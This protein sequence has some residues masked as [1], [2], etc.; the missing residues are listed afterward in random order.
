VESESEVRAA[1]AELAKAGISAS[2]PKLFAQYAPDY[3]A[4]FFS[5]PDGLRLEIT[6]YRRERR[7][8]HDHWDPPGS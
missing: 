5:D 6:N 3:F 4:V 1:A 7:Q 8:R 2:E